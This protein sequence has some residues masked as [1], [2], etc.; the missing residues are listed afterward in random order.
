MIRCVVALLDLTTNGWLEQKLVEF[1]DHRSNDLK[2]LGVDWQAAL[3]AAFPNHVQ[4]LTTN[5]YEEAKEMAF[6]QDWQ[7]SVLEVD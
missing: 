3:E 2:M 7:F 6:D 1:E 5:D 4:H